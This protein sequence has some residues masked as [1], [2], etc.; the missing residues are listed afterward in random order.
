MH[1]Q[2][3]GYFA[4]MTHRAQYQGGKR[5]DGFTKQSS[6]PWHGEESEA[7]RAFF[8]SNKH[9]ESV[10]ST[11]IDQEMYKPRSIPRWNFSKVVFVHHCLGER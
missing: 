8:G 6:P 11:M 9:D 1:K 10:Y 5:G 4:A 2:I 3:P 7:G